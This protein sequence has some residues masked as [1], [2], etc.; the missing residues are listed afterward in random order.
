M[1]SPAMPPRREA[2]APLRRLLLGERVGVGPPLRVA[3]VDP[4]RKSRRRAARG[5]SGSRFVRS[6]FGSMTSVG[7]ADEQ[8]LLEEHDAEAGL[9]RPGH[10]D[11]HAVG[12]EVARRRASPASRR[13]SASRRRSAHR[14]TAGR[15]ERPSSTPTVTWRA[16]Q[17]RTLGRQRSSRCQRSLGIVADT[18]AVGVDSGDLRGVRA[19][20]P[21]ISGSTS[22][23]RPTPMGRGRGVL[24]R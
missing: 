8:R 16:M 10:A 12:R 23:T 24:P 21:S 15:S 20:Q 6:P 18:F 2:V 19:P 11:D 13:G 1:R 3:V 4:G 22:S 9:A 17:L 14:C 7:H 5:T